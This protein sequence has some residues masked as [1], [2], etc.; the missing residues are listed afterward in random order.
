MS[1]RFTKNSF[2]KQRV[3]AAAGAVAIAVVGT[4]SL[5]ASAMAAPILPVMEV[6]DITVPLAPTTL[7]GVVGGP[8]ALVT[9][10]QREEGYLTLSRLDETSG[11]WVP[12][13]GK[14]TLYSD[15]SYRIP[16]IAPGTYE[17]QAVVYGEPVDQLTKGS[18]EGKGPFSPAIEVGAT[19]TT[20]HDV[21]LAYV[22]PPGAATPLG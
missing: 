13:S 2:A 11:A 22:T 12:V 19:T 20:V 6:P 7:T 5:S 9:A 21:Q 8:P 15:L 4:L 18:T 1:L 17:I 14:Y 16:Q 3:L 10:I